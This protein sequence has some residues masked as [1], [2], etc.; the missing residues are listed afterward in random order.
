MPIE[1][2]RLLIKRKSRESVR[3]FVMH[4]YSQQEG[5]P[6]RGHDEYPPSDPTAVQIGGENLRL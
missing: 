4:Y 2:A 1:M 5:D 3:E 6:E